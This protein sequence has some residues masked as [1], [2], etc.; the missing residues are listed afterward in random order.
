MFS[1]EG[2]SVARCPGWNAKDAGWV[3]SYPSFRD[4][5]PS[6]SAVISVC[7]YLP[8]GHLAPSRPLP[9]SWHPLIFRHFSDVCLSLCDLV[10]LAAFMHVCFWTHPW[11][12][13]TCT[14]FCEE[15]SS[16]IPQWAGTGLFSPLATGAFIP[17]LHRCNFNSWSGITGHMGVLILTKPLCHF[18]VLLVTWFSCHLLLFFSF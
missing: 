3:M 2:Q 1:Y 11:A 18:T 8:R 12:A 9:S 17:F 13:H 10:W 7:L 6:S 4:I 16:A 5:V 15:N 14:P